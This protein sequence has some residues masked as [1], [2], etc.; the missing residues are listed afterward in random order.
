MKLLQG[1]CLEL[2]KEIPDESV[3]LILCDLPYGS[4]ASEWDSIIPASLLWEQYNRIIT[5]NGS[6]LLFANGLFTP[7]VM[8]SNINS[9]KYKYV[10]VKNTPTNF[11]HAKNR[12]MTKHEDILVFSNAP[13]GHASLLGNR[14]MLYNP[15]GLIPIQKEKKASPNRFGTTAGKRKSHVAEYI[16]S[17]TNYPN[18][19]LSDFPETPSNKKMHPNEKPVALLEYLVKTYTNEGDTVLDNCMGSGSTGVACVNTGRNFIGIELDE[20]YF[21]IAKNRIEMTQGVIY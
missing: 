1:D 9:Y 4:T 21:N 8:L 7:M 18:D 12:P 16:Q 14:R 15:Q 2:M 17:Y 11:V 19:I 13:M 3:N 6:I 20:S 10:W 5:H